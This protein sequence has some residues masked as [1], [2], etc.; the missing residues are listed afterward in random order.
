MMINAVDYVP[1]TSLRHSMRVAAAT[2]PEGAS[3]LVVDDSPAIRAALTHTLGTLGIFARIVT[4]TDGF[5][6]YQALASG[7]F[8]LVLCDLNMPRCDGIQFLR[9]RAANLSM[10]NLPVL[11]LTGST[12]NESK[13]TALELGACD[14]VN[15]AA[16]PAELAARI[17]VHLRLKQT[18]DALMK[19]TA[20]LERLCRTDALTG[21]ANRRSLREALD[22]E[23]S[24]ATRYGRTVSLAMLDV[25]HFKRLNDT[26]GHPAGD[27][28]LMS[29][30]NVLTRSVRKNDFVGRY[31]G[32]EIAVILPETGM[33]GAGVLTERLRKAIEEEVIDWDG[34]PMRVTV[35]IGVAS[36]SKAHGEST[37]SLMRAADKALYEAKAQGR[38]RVVLAGAESPIVSL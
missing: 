23:V 26:Y 28:A 37:D 21:L 1:G 24:R 5:A 7:G 38:N 34:Q 14:Y 31:G 11:V 20:E 16:A 6:A 4:A 13:I 19:K 8:D 27:H 25:D 36:V 29:I 10:R 12:D 33:H 15:K 17:A 2:K 32:E 3:V 22:S 9:L 35:S 18:H 30:A